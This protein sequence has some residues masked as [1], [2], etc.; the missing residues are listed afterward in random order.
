MIR[1]PYSH[2]ASKQRYHDAKVSESGEKSRPCRRFKSVAC[3]TYVTYPSSRAGVEA[4]FAVTW[5]ILVMVEGNIVT[6]SAGQPATDRARAGDRLAPVRTLPTFTHI[7]MH[8]PAIPPRKAPWIQTVSCIVQEW[9]TYHGYSG[10]WENKFA[11]KCCLGLT[12]Y[13]IAKAKCDNVM[14]CSLILFTMV[15]GI[16]WGKLTRQTKTQ[17]SRTVYINLWVYYRYMV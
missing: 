11:R 9:I 1:K 16:V 3:E 17:T 5:L 12:N 10:G 7:V 14:S 6:L 2:F 8:T 13:I 4:V 15:L